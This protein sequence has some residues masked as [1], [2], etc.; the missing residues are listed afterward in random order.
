MWLGN[1]F[2]LFIHPLNKRYE[3]RLYGS[4]HL[5]IITN[6]NLPLCIQCRNFIPHTTYYPYED[7]PTDNYGK[8][9]MFGEQ[10]VVTGQI[11]YRYASTCRSGSSLCNISG[12]YFEVKE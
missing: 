4:Q 9:K 2:F 8:C 1:L 11:E 12:K 5:P 3:V 7:P 10:N 6:Q